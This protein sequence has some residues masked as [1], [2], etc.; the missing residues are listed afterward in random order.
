[1]FSPR[2][3]VIIATISVAVVLLGVAS[4]C[5]TAFVYLYDYQTELLPKLVYDTS[6]RVPT[7]LPP[8]RDRSEEGP[9]FGELVRGSGSPATSF[10]G[11]WSRFRGDDYDAIVKNSPPL[12]RKFPETGPKILWEIS[13]GDGYAGAAINQGKVYIID[14]D[15]K[16]RRDAIRCLSLDKGQEIWTYS[17]PVMIS[18]NHGISRTIP[19]VNDKYCVTI[20]PMC[21]VTCLNSSTGELIWG[22]DMPKQYG[23][24]VPQWYAGQCPLLWQYDV[25]RDGKTE[26]RDAVIL[27]PCGPEALIVAVD[28]ATGEEIW[29]TPN[30][31]G[32]VQ[33]HTSVMPMK[34][35]GVDTFVYVGKNG[36]VGV[37]AD[38]GKIL[39]SNHDWKIGIATSPS[40]LI[41]SD[42]RV[43]LCGSYDGGGAM[44]QISK[45]ENYTPPTDEAEA[46]YKS[47]NTPYVAK[48]LYKKPPKIFSSEQ[49]TPLLFDGNIFALRLRSFDGKFICFDPEGNVKWTSK[50]RFGSNSAGPYMIA[51]GMFLI[52][53]DEGE[54]TLAEATTSE[55][56]L[57]DSYEV[58]P[59]GVEA[60]APMA[61]ANGILILRDMT[62]MYCIDLRQ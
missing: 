40:P 33:T 41:L 49:Q 44:L 8:P 37:A 56:K 15:L 45:S 22:I 21:H 13:V 43:F 27:A 30:P 23:T 24:T 26:K 47:D 34:L 28:C 11:S 19:A 54:L 38:N 3:I 57:L 39:W 6:K 12:I 17:Y 48:L 25:T 32:W 18:K 2:T 58:I 20:G 46:A 1:M 52:L 14:Y 53:S 62:R 55:F 16:K 42:N 61:F 35:D 9:T 50:T 60:W 7:P 4:V 5:S 59:E 51:D 31:F 10:P 36:T 29:R